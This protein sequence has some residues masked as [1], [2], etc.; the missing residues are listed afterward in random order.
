MTAFLIDEMFPAATAGLLRENYDHD[1]V[2][3]FE[4]GLR[5]ADAESAAMARAEGRAVVT[6]NVADFS[7]ERDAVLVFVLKR[8]LP[9]GGAQAKALAKV[10]DDWARAHP[11]PYVGPHWPRIV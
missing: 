11:R 5:A 10:L 2:H 1:A 4:V 3:V 9:A 6:E 7:A 8:N